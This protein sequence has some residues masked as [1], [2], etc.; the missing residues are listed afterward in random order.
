MQPTMTQQDKSISANKASM[1]NIKTFYKVEKEN[2]IIK[3]LFYA[4]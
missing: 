1:Q 4:L 2:I 3:K